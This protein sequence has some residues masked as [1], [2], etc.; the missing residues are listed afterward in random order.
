MRVIIYGDV[1]I[2]EYLL[3]QGA[4]L[5]LEGDDGDTPLIVAV[6][7]RQ[8]DY[9]CNMVHLLTEFNSQHE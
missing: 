9:Y 8:Q 1:E 5:N 3:K 6:I 2:V 7:Q 4:N